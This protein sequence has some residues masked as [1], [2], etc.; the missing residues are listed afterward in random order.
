MKIE[1]EELIRKLE[2]LQTQQRSKNEIESEQK[3]LQIK[4]QDM[5]QKHQKEIDE[6][7]IIH[8]NEKNEIITQENKIIE[9]SQSESPTKVNSIQNKQNISPSKVDDHNLAYETAEKDMDIG[10]VNK[11]NFT[12]LHKKYTELKEKHDN[13]L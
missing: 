6:L 10:I 7:K 3:D 1:K 8:E 13:V 11:D 4:H 5:Q 2:E 9:V 12:D